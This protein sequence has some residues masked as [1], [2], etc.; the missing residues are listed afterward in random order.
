MPG[1][2]IW[3]GL[4]ACH[5]PKG[6]KLRPNK[7]GISSFPLNPPHVPLL[8]YPHMAA[9]SPAPMR[10]VAAA[11]T[12]PSL[13]QRIT[14]ISTV[15]AVR[16][17]QCRAAHRWRPAQCRGKPAVSGVVEDDEEDTSREALNP[18]EKEEEST[19]AGSWELGWFRLDEVGMDILGI[20]VPAVLA[21]AADPITALVDT[22]FVGHIGN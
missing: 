4:V 16:L 8:F 1:W 5:G 18:E 20:A 17:H 19:G 11:F 13:S 12:P 7:H 9:T 14:R 15:S 22:A 10:S 21:L 6:E 2:P 3:P